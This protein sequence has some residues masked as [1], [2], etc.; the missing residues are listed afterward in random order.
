LSTTFISTRVQVM[1]DTA[2]LK[3]R[4]TFGLYIRYFGIGVLAALV[5][6][7]VYESIAVFF[8]YVDSPSEVPPSLAL[9]VAASA[10]SVLGMEIAI[11][12]TP[13][14]RRPPRFRLLGIHAT[15]AKAAILAVVAL[16]VGVFS[17]M[18][19]AASLFALPYTYIIFGLAVLGSYAAT[20]L[21]FGRLDYR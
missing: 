15:G 6:F 7:C 9:S 11:L 3:L 18:I 5:F 13:A 10:G 19:L 17:L 21:L 4:N 14:G 16:I 1:F 2:L 20:R 8:Y 12:T